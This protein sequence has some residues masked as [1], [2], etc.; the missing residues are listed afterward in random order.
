MLILSRKFKLKMT[1]T[2]Q[3]RAS[4]EMFIWQHTYPHHSLLHQ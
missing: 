1:L 3:L 2:Q 4:Q